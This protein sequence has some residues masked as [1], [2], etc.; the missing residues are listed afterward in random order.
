MTVAASVPND[1]GHAS[2]K[3]L[4]VPKSGASPS[5]VRCVTLPS[6]APIMS[7]SVETRPKFAISIRVAPGTLSS[8]LTAL[9]KAVKLIS[10][11]VSARCDAFHATKKCNI[12]K[13]AHRMHIESHDS[14][15]ITV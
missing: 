14:R 9:N 4:R 7:G 1:G 5:S 11:N 12:R 3:R 2:R 6:G 10:V 15:L 8:A 13:G